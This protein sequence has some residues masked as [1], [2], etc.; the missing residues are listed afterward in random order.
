ME[1]RIEWFF[2][3]LQNETKEDY[4]DIKVVVV[5]FWAEERKLL[6]PHAAITHVPPKPT[7]WQGRHRL[8]RENYFAASNARNTAICLAED[9]WIA[10]V[11]DVSVLLPG[12]LEAVR[13]GMAENYI[14]LGA[15]KKVKD[16][17][18]TQG[19]VKSFTPFPPGVD[20]RWGS[21]D[22]TRAVPAGGSWMFGCSMAGPVEAFL[23]INGFDEDCD[24]MGSEDYIAGMMLEQNGWAFRYDRRML[25]YESEELHHVEAAFKRIIKARTERSRFAEIDASHTILNRVREGRKAAP[26][27][28]GEGGLRTLRKKILNGEPFPIVQ[29]QEHDWRDGQAIREM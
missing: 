23:Q 21:G 25:T 6:N 24:S 22:E 7:V 13:R 26:N 5:D 14:V 19:E 17:V 28:F 10:F 11:D 9:G 3:S 27:Y 16:L 12:W 4:R 29:I 8:T 2:D 15:Y 20:S 1:P 18:V